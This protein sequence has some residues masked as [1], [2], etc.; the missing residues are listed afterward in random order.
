INLVAAPKRVLQPVRPG[1]DDLAEQPLEQDLAQTTPDLGGTE[2][3]L[4]ARD[5]AADLGHPPR[6]L[7][8]GAELAVDLAD[9]ARRLVE[10][11]THRRLRVA[12]EGQAVLELAVDL[13]CDVVELPGHR[14]PH[15]PELLDHLAAELA[16]LLAHAG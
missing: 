3:L 4:E 12:E 10:A 16:E 15:I 1:R 7:G 5:V 11:L 6:G 9:R 14:R 8:E 2:D 13:L